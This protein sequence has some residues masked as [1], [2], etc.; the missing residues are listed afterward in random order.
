MIA[1]YVFLA[2]LLF[3]NIGEYLLQYDKDREGEL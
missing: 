3:L 1:V 2:F